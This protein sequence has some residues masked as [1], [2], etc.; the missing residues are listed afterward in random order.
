MSASLAG[1]T[2]NVTGEISAVDFFLF[3]CAIATFLLSAPW[4]VIRSVLIGNTLRRRL[5]MYW[6]RKQLEKLR[7]NQDNDESNRIN[8]T[9]PI[10]PSPLR[11]NYIAQS[12][13]DQSSDS[14]ISE[15][16]S[17]NDSQSE[18]SSFSVT[19]TSSDT[20]SP[21]SS[22]D[23]SSSQLDDDN[24]YSRREFII[25]GVLTTIFVILLLIVYEFVQEL[26]FMH[27]RDSIDETSGEQSSDS[28][29]QQD[30]EYPESFQ[31][32]IGQLFI[33]L[34][35]TILINITSNLSFVINSIMRIWGMRH[36][37]RRILERD[38]Y[39]EWM[40]EELKAN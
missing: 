6:K 13:S 20:L 12:D 37:R 8:D 33:I 32:R 31:H 23:R 30:P 29:E 2:F 26:L 21:C 28:A 4:F 10:I 14:V 36:R 22:F 9:N 7:N 24:K 35:P 25:S 17:E 11:Q 39:T 34:I 1:Q 19:S 15:V 3:F 38:A 16:V 5:Q 40:I 27:L 18:S